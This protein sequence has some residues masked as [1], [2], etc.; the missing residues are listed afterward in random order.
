MI[1]QLA[2]QFDFAINEECFTY[3]ECS[4]YSGYFVNKPVVVI[5]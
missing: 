3:N 5:E 4:A 1:P 2:S